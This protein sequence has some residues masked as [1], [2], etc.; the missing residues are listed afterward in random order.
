MTQHKSIAAVTLLFTSGL[1][2]C[3]SAHAQTFSHYVTNDASRW[4]KEF[5]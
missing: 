3:L 2:T 4:K 1:L 5:S